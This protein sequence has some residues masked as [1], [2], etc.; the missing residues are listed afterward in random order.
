M[1]PELM[2]SHRKIYEEFYGI[3][4]PKFMH[5]H[6]IDGNHGNND[7]LN[8]KL[9]TIKEHYDIHFSQGDYGA[10]YLLGLKLNISNEELSKLASLSATKANAEGKCG[11]ILGHASAAGKKGGLKGGKYAK[12]NRTGIFALSPEKNK[13][14]HLNSVISRLIK[15]GKMCAYPR[16]EV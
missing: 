7:P 3:K 4:I 13:E 14:R 6:H 8:L 2:R 5:I 10:A 9:V 11:F 15:N 12:E 16:K 1:G